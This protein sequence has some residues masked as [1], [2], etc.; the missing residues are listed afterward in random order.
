M[1][2]QRNHAVHHHA[3]C[4]H[5]HHDVGMHRDRMQQPLASFVKNV[6]GKPNQRDGVNERSQYAGA[7]ISVGLDRVR[8]PRLQ[9]HCHQ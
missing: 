6:A 9:E 3:H 1:Q 8:R 2:R 7:V 4:C 5:R